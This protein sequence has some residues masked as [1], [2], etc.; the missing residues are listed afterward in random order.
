M[1][2]PCNGPDYI[3]PTPPP[4]FERLNGIQ[5]CCGSFATHQTLF[6]KRVTGNSGYDAVEPSSTWAGIEL[7]GGVPYPLDIC[8]ISALR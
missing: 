5:A 2:S 4:D 1:L 7:R 6:A 3:A 8:A